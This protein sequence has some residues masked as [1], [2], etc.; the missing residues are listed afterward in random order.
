M[1]FS[2]AVVRAAWQRAGGR[3]ECGRSSCG[4]GPWRCGKILNWNSR[5]NDYALG[6]WEA[7][8]MLDYI[9]DD[10]SYT[11]HPL[12]KIALAHYQFESI[13]PFRDG[14]GRTGRILNVLFL[15][16]KGYLDAPILYASSYIIKNKNE[17]YTLLRTAKETE[18]YEEIVS[19]MLRSFK[20]TA[21]HTLR[22]VENITET[23]KTAL[24]E[25][26]TQRE[27]LR[28]SLA[29]IQLERH[30]FTKEEIV[31][32]ISQ[33]KNGDINDVSFQKEIIDVFVNSVYVYDD[34][35]LLAFNYKD[36]T[37][38]ITLEEINTILSSDTSNCIQP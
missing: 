37:R 1:A 34:K 14:N 3:C 16:Q 4:H 17:Y 38:T 36:G 19:Y 26:E 10:D 6:G 2:D 33:F 9:Y 18:Q 13:H 20:D 24:D 30:K 25:L 5:G 23:T 8:H 12:I 35:L 21:E 27:H 7:H 11:L 31:A 22:I 15:C 32:W 28:T 29:Q